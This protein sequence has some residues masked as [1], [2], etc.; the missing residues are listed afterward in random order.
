[1][2]K[3]WGIEVEVHTLDYSRQVSKSPD[4]VISQ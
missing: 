1:M 4:E 3:R 2:G